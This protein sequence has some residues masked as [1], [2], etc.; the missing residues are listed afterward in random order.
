[1]QCGDSSSRMCDSQEDTGIANTAVWGQRPTYLRF[2]GRQRC[3][4]I[5][6]LLRRE[7]TPSACG[8]KEAQSGD[9]TKLV[10]KRVASQC[11]GDSSRACDLQIKR[12]ITIDDVVD[13]INNARLSPSQ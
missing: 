4:S 6:A 12:G 1:M 13:C 10:K 7:I 8:L 11:G 3:L 2:A 5:A 9:V